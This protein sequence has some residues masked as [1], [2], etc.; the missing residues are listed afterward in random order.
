MNKEYYNFNGSSNRLG[1]SEE[2]DKAG[3]ISFFDIKLYY[4]AILIKTVLYWYKKQTHR[5]MEQNRQPRNKSKC[6]RLTIYDKRGMNIQGVKDSL[7]NKLWWE[8]WTATFL[9]LDNSP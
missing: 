6:I 8:N 7:F 5:S 4:K 2:K 1:N 3:N 9:K